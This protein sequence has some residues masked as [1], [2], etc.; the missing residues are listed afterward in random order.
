MRTAISKLNIK[1]T[2]SGRIRKL[3]SLSKLA[4]IYAI[5]GFYK[6]PNEI[7]LRK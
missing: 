5:K 4:K 1:K 6:I 3:P 7:C 2:V